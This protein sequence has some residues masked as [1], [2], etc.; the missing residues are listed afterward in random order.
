V[1]TAKS[2][3]AN[4]TQ[5]GSR[6]SFFLS[7]ASCHVPMRQVPFVPC[8]AVSR[9]IF[10]TFHLCHVPM[11]QVPFVPRSAVSRSFFATFRSA[12]FHLCHVPMR[13][14]PF[15]PRSA[16][17]RSIFATFHVYHVPQCQVPFVPRFAVDT[18]CRRLCTKRS[19]AVCGFLLWQRGTLVW[20]DRSLN[21]DEC[22]TVTH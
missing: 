9:S 7:L 22:K 16:V 3:F 1:S 21:I 2:S 15:V 6:S 17:S 4:S 18:T 10:A 5:R 13:Q 14:V 11:R 20:V 19:S 12:T 8:S